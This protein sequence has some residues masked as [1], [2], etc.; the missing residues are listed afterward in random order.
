VACGD[1]L[2]KRYELYC[3]ADRLFYGSP[4]SGVT[5]GSGFRGTAR[6]L[7]AG[8]E[9]VR[10]G[11]WLVFVPPGNALPPQG[12]KIHVSACRHN[13]GH[14]LG[15]VWDYCTGRGISFKYLRSR[16]TLHLRNA[17]YAP[18]G[19]S[20]KLVTICPV[21]DA[22]LRV[23]LTGLGEWLAGQ[24]G[25]Y[26]LSDLRYGD[27]PLYVRYGGMAGRYCG[28][29]RGELVPAI[30]G[31]S[32]RLVPGVRRPVF[33]VPGWVSLP[34]FPEPHLAA[35]NA[36]TLA[37]R[38]YRVE[39]A[40][41]FSNGGGVYLATDSRTGER[42]V[43]KEARPHAGP[44]AGG[45]DAVARL[46][47]ERAVCRRVEDAVAAVR[48]RGA[49]IND[50]HMFNR[51]RLACLRLAMF[52]P[53]TTLFSLHPGKAAQLADAIAE[54]F[55]VPREFLERAVREVTDH[56]PGPALPRPVRLA[57]SASSPTRA[58][59]YG[60]RRG[61]GA[62]RAGAGGRAGTACP[63]TSPPGPP[64]CCS[65]WPPPAR[66]AVPAQRTGGG[67]PA[68]NS[69]GR[70][71]QDAPPAGPHPG[72]PQ[73]ARHRDEVRSDGPA[74]HAGHEDNLGGD[75]DGANSSLSL[76][77]HSSH[78]ITVCLQY[79]APPGDRGPERR[80]PGTAAT[81][82]RYLRRV[83]SARPRKESHA[84]PASLR[85]PRCRC[86][87][88]ACATGARGRAWP[89]HTR[90]AAAAHAAAHPGVGQIARR[91][92]DRR[93]CGA[94]PCCQPR[95]GAPWTPS[96]GPAPAAA[97]PGPAGGPAGWL[98]VLAVP[99]AV[100]AGCDALS[101]F[102]PGAIAADATAWLRQRMLRHLLVAG[103]RSTAASR[104]ETSSAA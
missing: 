68:Q 27:G 80:I 1:I 79:A 63:W 67:R 54:Y 93:G 21:D 57:T 64:A 99:A 40:L 77:C 18:R 47:R 36:A 59:A 23:I 43:L 76:L 86:R 101:Q 96:S 52:M 17:K 16:L 35:R 75:G 8:W 60:P 15:A 28:N 44:S 53:M 85:T 4:N 34:A 9:R 46:H 56:Q 24:P 84:Y 61:R 87:S 102:G 2:D 66:P 58:A 83:P 10:K 97:R 51:Y 50:L 3:L 25:P 65:A 90:R 103:P 88:R 71:D 29:E 94:D 6:P 100:S 37:G 11:E 74:G 95:S 39:G 70:P 26:I 13:A 73:Q 98:A 89:G 49:I 32:S 20:G 104:R 45:A 19:G 69:A 31:G 38:P 5:G 72:R 30:T 33:G 82:C 41:H 7:P 14:V 48:A 92:R 81:G 55:P 42:V 62:V 91:G 78:S 22:Q 12:R